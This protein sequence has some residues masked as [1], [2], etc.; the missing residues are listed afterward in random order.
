MRYKYIC[1]RKQCDWRNPDGA[2]LMAHRCPTG[3]RFRLPAGEE[4]AQG[5]EQER[6]QEWEQELIGDP[7][8]EAHGTQE[9]Q[10]AAGNKR[11]NAHELA[12]GSGE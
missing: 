9:A 2:C 12:E 11:R 8:A 10:G 7:P 4:P 5:L 3:D 6:E 1:V